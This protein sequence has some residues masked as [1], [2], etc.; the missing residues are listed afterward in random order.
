[1]RPFLP[2]PPVIPGRSDRAE[3]GFG[4]RELSPKVAFAQDEE[5]QR[6]C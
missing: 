5:A 3:P 2:D 1:L 4:S 6:A